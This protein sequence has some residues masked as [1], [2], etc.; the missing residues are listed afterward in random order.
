MFTGEWWFG[1]KEALGLKMDIICDKCQRNFKLPDDKIPEG[2]TATLRCPQCKNKITVS[3][4]KQEG[5]FDFE[6]DEGNTETTDGKDAEFA[7]GEDYP[8]EYEQPD[9]MFDFIEDEGKTALIC[10][11]DKSIKEKIKPVLDFMEFH[12]VEAN[13]AREAIKKLRYNVFN[14][15]F[16]NEEFDT[17]DPDENGVLIYLERM[18][19]LER[20]KIFVA[21]LSRRFQTLDQMTAL[22]KSVNMII[23]PENLNEFEKVLKH[24]LSD[25]DIFYRLYMENLKNTGRV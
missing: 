16:I 10:E 11:S 23:N 3:R 19:M 20:R 14:L 6:T 22:H 12:I 18:Q 17:R 9:R 7:F 5:D 25:S 13:S 15:I 4:E 24:G 21:L 8:E 2:R 1:Q